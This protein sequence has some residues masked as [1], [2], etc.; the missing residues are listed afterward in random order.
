LY[1]SNQNGV[2]DA[3][4]LNN[5]DPLF[6]SASTNDYSITAISPARDVGTLTSGS[7][8]APG[9]DITEKIRGGNANSSNVGSYPDMGCYEN[10]CNAS[11]GPYYVN[12]N[13]TSGDVYCSAVGSD[14]NAGTSS[15]PFLT[16]KKA[17]NQCGCGGATIFVDKGTY[18]DD[19][20]TVST[21]ASIGS[22][23]IIQGAGKSNTIFNCNTDGVSGERFMTISTDATYV[24]LSDMTI[25]DA[26]VS[27][28]GAGINVTTSGTVT[29]EDVIFNNCD[30]S[31]TTSYGGGVYVSLSST[32][33]INRCTFTGCAEFTSSSRGA[34]VFL[35]G[36]SGKTN[37]VQNCLFYANTVKNSNSGVLVSYSNS[38]TATNNIINCTFSSNTISG[39][40]A[41]TGVI[42]HNS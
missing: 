26:D 32:A 35:D 36:G 28:N 12:D 14:A 13:A 21:V 37:T 27:G 11:G 31:G 1:Q 22:P 29:I 40:P 42:Y 20:L 15:A 38:V 41:N 5:E 34:A 39:T 24:T 4:S 9:V 33:N 19:N 25:Q 18:S 10:T 8:N 6:T 7:I 3:Y 16:L 23:L 30:L 2:V 17:I